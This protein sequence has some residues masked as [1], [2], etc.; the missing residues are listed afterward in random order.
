MPPVDSGLARPAD[1]VGAAAALIPAGHA[2]VHCA[3]HM[4]GHQPACLVWS[5][6]PLV[7]VVKL[8]AWER[9]SDSVVVAVHG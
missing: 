8:P 1:D 7:G 3:D 5:I 6:C 4:L 9:A 2:S